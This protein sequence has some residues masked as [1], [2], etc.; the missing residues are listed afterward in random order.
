VKSLKTFFS[1]LL[2]GLLLQSCSLQ[3]SQ[4]SSL[5]LAIK[6]PPNELQNFSWTLSY[7]TYSAQVYLVSSSAGAVFLNDYGDR[8]LFDGWSLREINGLGVN[9]ANWKVID[10]KKS[11]QFIRGKSLT[12]VDLCSAWDSAKVDNMIRYTQECKN[13]VSYKNSIL[14][15]ENGYMILLRQRVD[16]TDTFLTLSKDKLSNS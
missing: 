9:R 16:G 7:G 12:R 8:L 10:S 3:S 15:D 4:L 13:F 1:V 6:K 5:M 14:I 2:I 11:R